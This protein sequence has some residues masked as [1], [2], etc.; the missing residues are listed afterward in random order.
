VVGFSNSAFLDTDKES[1]QA[2]ARLWTGLVA[3]KHGGTS[4][5]KIFASLAEIERE[6]SSKRVDLLILL[7][8]EYLELKERI[9]L[10]PLCVSAK[11]DDVYDRLALIVRRDSGIRTIANLRGKNLVR[12]KGLSSDGRDQWLDTLLMRNGV[13]DPE[14]FFAPGSR[15]VFKPSMAVMPVF[16]RKADACI[17][18]RSS[19][20]VMGELNPQLNR[21][22]TVLAESP[23]RSGSVIA[24]RKGLSP[25]HREILRDILENLDHTPQGQQLLTLFRMSRLVPF[26][27]DYLE[28]LEKLSRE[29]HSLR[30][31]SSWRN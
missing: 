20:K 28:P 1:S 19:L 6:V 7:A 31:R 5:T 22:L 11:K 9:P 2:V 17:V 29:H 13:R 12:Q 18:T 15:H 8:S 16:F 27:P 14:R 3:R 4:D 24:V 21:E 25:P 26:H 30:K 23:P 10:E